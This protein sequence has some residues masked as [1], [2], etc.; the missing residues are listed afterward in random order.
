MTKFSTRTISAVAGLSIA[1]AYSMQLASATEQIVE[2]KTRDCA[3]IES[4]V[5]RLAC[6]DATY[7][8]GTDSAMTAVAPATIEAVPTSTVTVPSE[9]DFGQQKSKTELE[10]ESLDSV[11]TGVDRDAYDKLI[12]ELDNGQVWRQTESKHFPIDP[13][14]A[15]EIRH[16]AM[17]SYK[18]YVKGESRWTR[19]R[20]VK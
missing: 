9:A 14:Q 15:T 2:Q 11:I 13:G 17:G 19:V 5:E 6:F 8:D 4:S 16:G 3:V 18:L 7:G 10:G 1:L 20:R 12:F